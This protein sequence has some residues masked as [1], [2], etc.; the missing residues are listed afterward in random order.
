VADLLLGIWI[1]MM[2]GSGLPS[3]YL[4]GLIWLTVVELADRWNLAR[5]CQKPVRYGESLP[6][7]LLSE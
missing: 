1:V 2:F 5:V 4:W 7:L 3:L 6:Y